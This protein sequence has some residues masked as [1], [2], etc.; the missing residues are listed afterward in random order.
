[1]PI[2][3]VVSLNESHPQH[4]ET[5]NTRTL[6]EPPAQKPYISDGTKTKDKCPSCGQETMAYQN[7][8]L[9]C[10]SCGYSKCG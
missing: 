6:R 5:N 2:T 7:G 3:N 8:C 4:S 10:M 9:T 1:M